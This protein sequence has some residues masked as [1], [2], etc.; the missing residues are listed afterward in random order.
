MLAVRVAPKEEGKKK[1]LELPVPVK[2]EKPPE[3]NQA[4]YLIVSLMDLECSRGFK[5]AEMV[6]RKGGRLV[7]TGEA[8]LISEDPSRIPNFVWDMHK[9]ER[10][11]KESGAIRNLW[12]SLSGGKHKIISFKGPDAEQN[13]QIAYEILRAAGFEEGMLK[14][15]SKRSIKILG[16]PEKFDIEGLT[17]RLAKNLE[18]V[19]AANAEAEAAET[20][21]ARA[22]R[23]E[24]IKN[25]FARMFGNDDALAHLDA[26]K[27][28]EMIRYVHDSASPSEAMLYSVWFLLNKRPDVVK[29][30]N[31]LRDVEPY[32]PWLRPFSAMSE[33][34]Y[35]A[36]IESMRRENPLGQ[37]SITPTGREHGELLAYE[38]RRGGKPTDLEVAA[39]A[40]WRMPESARIALERGERAEIACVSAADYAKKRAILEN[41][42]PG[43]A[44]S[45]QRDPSV[46]NEWTLIV[47]P[48]GEEANDAAEVAAQL[49]K[50]LGGA[51]DSRVAWAQQG[52]KESLSFAAA[53]YD[54]VRNY[55]TYTTTFSI[56]SDPASV[57]GW[58]K[59]LVVGGMGNLRIKDEVRQIFLARGVEI[60]A[61]VLSTTT[62]MEGGREVVSGYTYRVTISGEKVR[63]PLEI[64]RNEERRKAMEPPS[65]KRIA[66]FEEPAA[67]GAQKG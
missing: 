53:A 13:A 27:A 61:E 31:L 67:G 34:E 33:K 50:R 54:A 32:E 7:L 26:Q 3:M 20:A 22:A 2:A 64:A 8:N 45:L 44:I 6:Y 12:M 17:A 28:A 43:R 47:H 48:K 49:R 14:F 24:D 51:A 46:E 4:L 65:L 41:L 40:G 42:Y 62:R 11:A 9:I 58:F 10:K 55:S 35:L 37:A 57:P 5:H 18:R 19:K 21:Q 29:I 59:P 30:V 16:V 15:A 39:A 38:K 56:T 60:R 66:E 25:E 63:K 1:K 36:M 52:R 23:Q